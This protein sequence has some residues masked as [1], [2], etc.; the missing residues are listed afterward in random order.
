MPAF[1]YRCPVTG[2]NVQGHSTDTR[3]DDDAATYQAVTC[4]ACARVHLV[5]S[6]T[7]KVAGAERLPSVLAGLG[8]S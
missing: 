7:G 6:K 4:T 8:P 5:N 2:Y 1:I 3:L